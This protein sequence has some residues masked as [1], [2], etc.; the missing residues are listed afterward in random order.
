M[1]SASDA[2]VFRPVADKAGTVAL[3]DFDTAA[4]APAGSGTA[5]VAGDSDI[6]VRSLS[7]SGTA[8]AAIVDV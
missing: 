8:A 1:D 2:V 4:A 7:G 6:A 5:A 3:A